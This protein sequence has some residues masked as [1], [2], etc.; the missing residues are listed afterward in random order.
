VQ[1]AIDGYYASPIAA[2]GKIFLFSEK[3]LA[4]VLK[5]GAEWEVLQVNDFEEPIYATPAIAGNRMFVRTATA[6]YAIGAVAAK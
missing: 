4:A 2:D 6:L 1:G 5:P 3:G